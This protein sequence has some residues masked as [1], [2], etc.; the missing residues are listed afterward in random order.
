[1]YFDGLVNVHGNGIGAVLISSAGAHFPVATQLK[2]FCT[3]NTREYEAYITGV[4]TALDINI[5]D[6]E[7]YGDFSL[8]IS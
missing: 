2:F 8:I 1:M 6:L 5:I 7:V 4:K 3:N